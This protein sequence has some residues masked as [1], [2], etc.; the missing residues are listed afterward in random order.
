MNLR[1]QR[2]RNILKSLPTSVFATALFLTAPAIAD[3]PGANE[4]RVFS[5]F[6]DRY[7]YPN[8]PGEAPRVNVTWTDASK[9]CRERGKRLCTEM[10]WETACRGPAGLAYGY[11]SAFVPGNCNSPYPTADGGWRRDFGTALAGSFKNCTNELGAYD[12][13]GNVWEWTSSY[14]SESNRWRVVRGG[15]WFHN[16][17][18][19]RSDGRYGKYLNKDYS[20]DL[21]GFRCCRD[22]GS[23]IE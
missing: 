15:S 16:V 23:D 7:E 9:L 5:F 19:A 17:N 18:F 6:I 12:M 20:L 22:A 21:I 11:G 8:V 10:E 13:I 3:A 2:L 4:V 1:T 14:F